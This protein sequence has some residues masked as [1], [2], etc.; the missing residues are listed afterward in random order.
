MESTPQS[1]AES[2]LA[3]VPK[4]E[5]G[6]ALNQFRSIYAMTRQKGLGKKPED[7]EPTAEFAH[8]TALKAARLIDASFDIPVPVGETN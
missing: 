6:S 8:R 1:V 4:G 7:V 2:E 5:P 3:Q